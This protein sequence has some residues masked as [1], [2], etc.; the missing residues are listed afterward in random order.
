MDSIFAN[1]TN[2]EFEQML[3]D[4]GFNYIKVNSGDG[5]ILYKGK[6]YKDIN[7]FDK[8]GAGK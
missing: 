4:S 6:L 2:E 5:G 3:E 1:L 8:E 7:D